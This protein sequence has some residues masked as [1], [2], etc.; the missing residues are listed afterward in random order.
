M[1][2]QAQGVDSENPENR[3]SPF[4]SATVF[5][6][7]LLDPSE[8]P[9]GPLRLSADTLDRAMVINGNSWVILQHGVDFPTD[10][11][12]EQVRQ[13]LYGAARRRQGKVVVR[14]VDGGDIMIYATGCRF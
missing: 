3:M 7:R 13:R 10:V 4:A 11:P 6:M 12:R 14:F 5:R 9:P 1:E 8:S 2:P